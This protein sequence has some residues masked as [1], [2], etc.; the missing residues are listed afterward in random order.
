MFAKEIYRERREILKKTIGKGILLFLG[1]DESGMNFEDNTYRYRQ[2]STFLYFFGLS[3]AGLNAIIDIDNDKEIIFADE[4]TIDHIVWMGTQPTLKEKAQ[5]VGVEE[6][7][8]SAELKKLLDKATKEGRGIHYLP[9][10]RAEHHIK[11]QNLLGIKPGEEQPS[12]DFIKA[13]VAQ[14]LIKSDIEIEELRRACDVTAD[15]H[16][17]AMKTLRPGMR[18]YEVSAA[19]EAAAQKSGCFLSFP[20]ICSTQGQTL[21]N[22]SHT[23]IIKENDM[24]LLDAGAETETGYAGDMSST[25]CAGKTFTSRQKDILRLQVESHRAAV[26]MLKPGTPFSQIHDKACSVIFDGLKAMNITKGDTAE[27][28]RAGAHAMFFPCGLGHSM[29]MDVHDMENLGEVWV[30]YD[31]QAKSTQFGRKSLRLARPLEKGYVLT[32]EPGIYFIPELIDYWKAEG[33]FTDFINY[34]ELEN[35]RDFGGLRNEEDYLITENGSER[36]G[37]YV[38]MTPEEIEALR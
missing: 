34:D 28:V 20:T 6:T 14:R 29:G 23:N 1:N 19:V 13:V 36:L 38:P 33:R 37:K 12:T 27:A 25:I 17:A 3:F 11:L 24:L 21:H 4:L 8:P 30:G 2:D 32:I 10:Y 35:W 15:M 9:A 5:R 22:H 26:S 31:G 7:R 18:E 16:I